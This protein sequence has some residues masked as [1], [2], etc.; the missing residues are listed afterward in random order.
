MFNKK[1]GESGERSAAQLLKSK[2]YRIIALNYTTKIGEIDIVAQHGDT[3]V[4]AEVKTR[5]GKNYGLAREAV[6][7]HKQRV[8]GMVA[9]QYLKASGGF[10]KKCRF[11]VLEVTP[12]GVNHIINAF[13]YVR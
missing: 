3:L 2:G 7:K 6:T 9:M 4:F 5:T 1:L 13:D 12:E 8:Y 10:G 11:D